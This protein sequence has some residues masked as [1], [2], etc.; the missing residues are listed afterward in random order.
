MQG[1]VAEIKILPKQNAKMEEQIT[2]IH[3]NPYLCSIMKTLYC[4]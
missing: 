3:K 2:E 1:Y 4:I